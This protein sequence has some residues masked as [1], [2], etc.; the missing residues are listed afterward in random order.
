M[1][2]F[3]DKRELFLRDMHKIAERRRR[4]YKAAKY[5]PCPK[6]RTVQVSVIALALLAKWKCRECRHK[7][8]WEPITLIRSD[9]N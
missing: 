6:C 8:V 2:T 7:W 3:S 1:K 5:N 9:S 4:I